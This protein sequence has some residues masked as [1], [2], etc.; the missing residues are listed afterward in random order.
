MSEQANHPTP[1]KIEP[2]LDPNYVIVLDANGDDILPPIHVD[3]RSLYDLIVSCVNAL[4]G[5]NPEAVGELVAHCEQSEDS[6]S[7]WTQLDVIVD[8]LRVGRGEE[9]KS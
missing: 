1:W 8:H 2:T 3:D 6:G 4:A 9:R 5:L 7:W